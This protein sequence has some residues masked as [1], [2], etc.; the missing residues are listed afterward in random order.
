MAYLVI[1]YPELS[2]SDYN[3]IQNYRRVN[4]PLYYSVVEP[5]FTFVFPVFDIEQEVFLQEA[6]SLLKGVKKIDF[7]L[8]CATINKD[9]FSDYFHI[10]LIPEEGYSKIVKLH[11]RLY[12]G[13]FKNNLRLEIDFIPHI[14]IG[15]SL[16]KFACKQ[17]VDEWNSQDFALS[18]T[19]A[20]M[21]IIK[22]ENNQVST[23]KELT[24]S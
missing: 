19:I 22:Y 10:L 12:S 17:M 3:R 9:A 1:S 7:T 13:L 11:D 21:S 23:I 6:T 8:R 20:S 18:G 4:D 24:L 16:D 14:G 5:H 15:N 2:L